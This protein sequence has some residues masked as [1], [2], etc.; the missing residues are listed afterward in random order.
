MTAAQRN[1]ARA[2]FQRDSVEI[3]QCCGGSGLVVSEEVRARA[4]AGGNKSFL[5]S[6]K[7]GQL[8]MSERGKL[9]GRPQEPTLADLDAVDRGEEPASCEEKAPESASS[10]PDPRHPGA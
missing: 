10:R 4:I 9:G 7:H 3:C 5:K 2:K 8:S 6:L 1:A